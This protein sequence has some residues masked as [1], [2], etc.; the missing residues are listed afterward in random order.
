M[1][2]V[3]SEGAL[4]PYPTAKTGGIL[5][6]FPTRTTRLSQYCHG[7]QTY[8]KKP[9]AQRFHDCPCGIGPIQRDLY[10][11]FLAAYLEPPD[12]F[13]SSAQYHAYWEGAD[14]RLR[15]ALERLSQRAKEGQ[16]LPRSV[17]ISG[18]RARLPQSLA[19]NQQGLVYRHGRLEALG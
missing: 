14:L 11:A 17:G 18:A 5:H 10:S 16:V 19:T 1:R 7:C 2:S 13:P 3:R 4:C 6:E 8:V 9:L 12:Y 15:A